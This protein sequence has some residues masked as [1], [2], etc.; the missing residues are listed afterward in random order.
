MNYSMFYY[1]LGIRHEILYILD[2]VERVIIKTHIIFL[3]R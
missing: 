3:T 2:I 1:F